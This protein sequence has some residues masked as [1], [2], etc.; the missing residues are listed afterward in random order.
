MSMRLLV[1]LVVA[2]AACSGAGPQPTV[3]ALP[4]AAPID[5]TGLARIRFA[6]GTTS[7]ILNDSLPARETRS[8]V[9][10][11]LQGQV[12]LVHA[13]AWSDP[14]GRHPAGEATVRVFRGVDGAE[15]RSSAGDGD[16]WS[17]RLPS[18]G[19]FVVRV[20]AGAAPVSY[21]LAVQ[22]PRRVVVDQENPT[23]SFS[24]LAPSRGPIDYII[25][26]EP[27]NRLEVALEADSAASSLH[28]Y[29]LDTGVQLARLSDR[30]R[31]FL[32]TVP[33]TQDYVVS[34]VP[35]AEQVRYDLLIT[36]R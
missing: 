18:S 17:G 31:R 10:G 28:I 23:T 25:K 21:T 15:L 8:Y 3:T 32:G 29:G 14:A 11:A 24:G 2:G 6:R 35:G 20:T 34:V 13:I 19:D 16:Q 26:A 33:T 1:C 9:L 4:A 12:M 27:G 36:L 7:G 5:T 30:R 22:I